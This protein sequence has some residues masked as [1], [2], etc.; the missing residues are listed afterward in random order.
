MNS[1]YVMQDLVHLHALV[2]L[3]PAGEPVEPLPAVRKHR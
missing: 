3:L 1:V 2:E